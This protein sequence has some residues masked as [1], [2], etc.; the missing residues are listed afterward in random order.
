MKVINEIVFDKSRFSLKK[1]TPA[2]VE[3]IEE[4]SEIIED[5]NI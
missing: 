3:Q 5:G 4:K 2:Q 1:T